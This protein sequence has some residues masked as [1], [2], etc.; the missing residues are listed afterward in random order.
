MGKATRNEVAFFLI[1]EE[2]FPMYR[3]VLLALFLAA[4][5]TVQPV[6]EIQPQSAPAIHGDERLNAV[7]WM[8]SSAEYRAAS[9]QAFQVAQRMLDRALNDPT[10]TAAEEQTG[11]LTELPAAVIVDIDETVLDNSPFEARQIRGAQTFS[12]DLWNTWV[13]E[14]KAEPVPGAVVFAREASARG[15]TIFY[16]SN[17]LAT[18]E[19]PT[20]ANLARVGFSLQTSIDQ[21]LLRNERPEWTSDKSLRRRDVAS[22]YRVLLIVGDDF[23]DFTAG[24][25][26]TVEQRRDVVDRNAALWGTKWIMLPNATYGS[27]ERAVLGTEPNLTEQQKLQRK[28]ERLN[29]AQ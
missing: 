21:V 24:A 16:I 15:V 23:N 4:C 14:A 18:Q 10:W 12:E 2:G 13:S 28:L 1:R 3:I 9:L 5:S 29:T 26:G 27:W 22:R 25:R 7:L 17:R 8:Q 19:E 11:D 20:R 6:V